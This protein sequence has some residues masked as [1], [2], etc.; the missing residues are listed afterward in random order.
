MLIVDNRGKK[1]NFINLW[2]GE[3]AY[4]PKHEI[5]IMK[6]T[7]IDCGSDGYIYNTVSLKDGYALVMES[8]DMVV[9]V[10]SKLVVGEE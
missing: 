1:T 5:Y 7:P 10:K 2:E 3:I 9:R 4:D 8:I 6:I